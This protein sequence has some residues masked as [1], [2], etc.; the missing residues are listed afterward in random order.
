MCLWAAPG[1]FLLLLPSH[2]PLTS[3]STLW[4]P[5]SFLHFLPAWQPYHLP[6]LRF[7]APFAL[8]KP[9][10]AHYSTAFTRQS[11][12]FR[13]PAQQDQAFL[14]QYAAYNHP[15]R[16]PTRSDQN[17]PPQD[18]ESTSAE[19]CQSDRAD[20]RLPSRSTRQQLISSS[21]S[22]Y[23]FLYMYIS[24]YTSMYIYINV[25]IKLCACI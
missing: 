20:Q 4:V 23:I 2:G 8:F 21:L 22:F 5:A 25:Y 13:T 18:Q 11:G 16:Y 24:M 12:Y 9:P 15:K 7:T 14:P 1:T 6:I 10:N 3:P 17:S 19:R